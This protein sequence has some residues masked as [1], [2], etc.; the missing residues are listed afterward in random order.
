MKLTESPSPISNIIKSSWGYHQLQD[1]GIKVIFK[2]ENLM[3]TSYHS[4]IGSVYE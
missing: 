1:L 4:L 3:E 2:S